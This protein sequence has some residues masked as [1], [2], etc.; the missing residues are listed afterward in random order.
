MTVSEMKEFLTYVWYLFLSCLLIYCIL[1][2]TYNFF[3]QIREE[4]ENK[5]MVNEFIESILNSDENNTK[6]DKK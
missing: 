2:I 1:G 4:H 5:K 6:D 3:K